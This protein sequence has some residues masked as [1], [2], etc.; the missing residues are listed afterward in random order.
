MAA[1]ELAMP[2]RPPSTIYVGQPGGVGG[3]VE[4]TEARRELAA[5]LGAGGMALPAADQLAAVR[6]WLSARAADALGDQRPAAPGLAD[7]VGLVAAAPVSPARR[8]FAILILDALAVPGLVPEH[9]PRARLER[10][11]CSLAERALPHI[12]YRAG[13]P[14]GADV[15]VRRRHLM[16]LA[17]SLDEYLQPPEPSIPTWLSGHQRE[18]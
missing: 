8:T 4:Q 10:D 17:A 11:V 1:E 14:F 16:A 18:Q 7:L 3:D 2:R 13:Y 9:G 5:I 15:E 12:L 6:S